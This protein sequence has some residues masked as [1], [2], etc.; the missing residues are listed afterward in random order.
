MDERRILSRIVYVIHNGLQ[1]KDAPKAYG[2][3]KTLGNR[4][5][6]WSRI[7]VSDRISD[8]LTEQP[9]RSKCLMVNATHRKPRRTSASLFKKGF[10]PPWLTE[11]RR[12]EFK[13]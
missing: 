7:G 9:G 13:I 6:R 4:F 1:W 8:A 5:I 2:V 3:H 12:P 10:S 11:K